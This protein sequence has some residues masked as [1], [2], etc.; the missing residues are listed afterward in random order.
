ML[1]DRY[2]LTILTI[3]SF[4]I[5]IG[6]ANKSYANN[7]GISLGADIDIIDDV[8]IGN[9]EDSLIKIPLIEDSIFIGGEG[10]ATYY[11]NDDNINYNYG[12][13]GKLGYSI[14]NI[15]LYGFLGFQEVNLA[16]NNQEKNQDYY[17]STTRS[18]IYG[19]GVAYGLGVMKIKFETS[20]FELDNK[21]SNSRERFVNS[22]FSVFVGF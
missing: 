18:P 3:L 16:D 11:N 14:I 12:L 2:F 9:N 6:H 19:Y 7:I 13:K 10:F 20:Y 17:F 21:L 15:D 5:L 4:F 8:I 1:T 22:G